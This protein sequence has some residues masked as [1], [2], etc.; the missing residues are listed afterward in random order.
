M[1][2]KQKKSFIFRFCFPY[3]FPFIVN[4]C[5]RRLSEVFTIG[6]EMPCDG[7]GMICEVHLSYHVSKM[8]E[9]IN[10]FCCGESLQS[11]HPFCSLHAFYHRETFRPIRLM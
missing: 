5:I 8:E 3:S 2:N 7:I 10:F 6:H 9:L 4:D 1:I 11:S